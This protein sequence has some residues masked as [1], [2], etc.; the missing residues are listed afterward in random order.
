MKKIIFFIALFFC[1]NVIFSQNVQIEGRSNTPNTLVRLFVIDDFVSWEEKLLA[2]TQTD[3]EGF[4]SLQVSI[5]DICFAHIAFNS[6]R[7]DIILSPNTSFKIDVECRSRDTLF[8]Y[9]DRFPPAILIEKVNDNNL[10][11]QIATIDNFTSAFILDHFNDLYRKRRYELLDSLKKRVFK[12]ILNPSVYVKQYADYKIA[13]VKQAVN[14]GENRKL[15]NDYFIGKPVLYNQPAYFELFKSLFSNYFNS[16]TSF[17]A[18]EF[19]KTFLA[20]YDAF[21]NYLKN[22]TL[23]AKNNRLA[24]LII[25]ENL[26]QLYHQQAEYQE[27][28]LYYINEIGKKTPYNEHKT[29]AQNLYKKLS[30]MAI[31]SPAPDFKLVDQHGKTHQLADYKNYFVL[32]QFIDKHCIVCSKQLDELKLLQDEFGA[33]V[34]FITLA[35]EDAYAETRKLFE[36]KNISWP[37]LN[38]G[39]DVML[40]EAYQTSIFPDYIILKPNN[41]VGMAPAPEPEQYLDYHL[42][43]IISHE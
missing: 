36:Q 40:L 5:S 20:G 34:K 39:K 41:K 11:K 38:L 23:L 6:E 28:V 42:R 17:T 33:K 30:R 26:N 24:E 3:S 18:Q 15:M 12:I 22:D 31:D 9:F 32:L 37:L 21:R 35:T 29:I 8:S 10:N 7:S 2:Q 13:T 1:F 16:T 14:R 19:N 4:F 43:H 25:I 27:T